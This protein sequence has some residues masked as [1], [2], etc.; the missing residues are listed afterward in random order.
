MDIQTTKL[1]LMQRILSSNKASLLAKLKSVNDNEQEKEIVG[2]TIKGDPL[3][4]TS[5]NEK[6]QRG[7]EDIKAGRVTSDE[8]LTK[9]IDTW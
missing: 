2:Y 8:D 9:E 1:E 4:I 5:M 7:E 3:T 6:L